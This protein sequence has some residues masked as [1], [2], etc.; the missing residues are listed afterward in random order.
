MIQFIG[1]N[2]IIKHF[3]SHITTWLFSRCSSNLLIRWGLSDSHHYVLD[4]WTGGRW[5]CNLDDAARNRTEINKW[6]TLSQVYIDTYYMYIM[7]QTLF[8]VKKHQETDKYTKW[9]II[10]IL[11]FHLDFPLKFPLDPQLAWSNWREVLRMFQAVL[12]STIWHS[13][14]LPTFP[15]TSLNSLAS[16]LPKFSELI[17][18]FFCKSVWRAGEEARRRLLFLPGGNIRLKLLPTFWFKLVTRLLLFPKFRFTW[19]S[20]FYS[21][22]TVVEGKLTFLC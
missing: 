8:N 16:L 10:L 3:S 22:A 1:S 7:S 4:H 11:L 5:V 2:P 12:S 14:P 19:H 13:A 15:H 6:Q 18:L 17:F 21:V 20:F 9:T